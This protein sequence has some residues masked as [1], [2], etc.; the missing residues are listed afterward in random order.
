MPP[1]EYW[2]VTLPR[3]DDISE[4]LINFIWELGALGVVEDGDLHAFFPPGTAPALLDARIRGYLDSL[5]QLGFT[6]PAAPILAPLVEEPWAE[7]W[8]EHFAPLAVGAR[9]LIVPPWMVTANAV[10]GALDERGRDSRRIQIRIEPGRAFGTGQHG[11]T[12]SC[13]VLLERAVARTPV[14]RALD[15]GTGSGILAIAAARLGVSQVLAIDTD[16]DAVA[17]AASNARLN[18]LAHRVRCEVGDAG[19]L[20]PPAPA[21][22]VVANLLAAAH[23]RLASHYGLLL[24]P[25]G[26]LIV[27]GILDREVIGIRETFA[28]A[29][30][31]PL[32]EER[33][34]GWA[35]LAFRRS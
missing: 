16:P 10:A 5:R 25:A 2:R 27:G 19:M 15:I 12:A 22:L 17:N 30:L 35:A 13:L 20:Y 18:G 29:A 26:T 23:A 8:R 4:G 1:V 3:S 21:G 31:T 32:D 14:E 24:E 7:A 33:V 11:S 6:A 34:G 9:L 28:S